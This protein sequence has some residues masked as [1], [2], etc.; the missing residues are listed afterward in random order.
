MQRQN[1]KIRRRLRRKYSI[2][3]KVFGTNERPRLCVKRS[4]NNIYAQIINDVEGKTLV[5]ASTIDKEIKQLIGDASKKSE[6]S[7]IVGLQIAKR[8]LEANIKR[9]TFDRNGYLY[10][11]R[12]K[13]LAEAAREGGLEF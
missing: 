8:A 4:L 3:K 9:V 10:H 2:R 6:K 1:L 7:K 12:V 5:S 11:G 13:I